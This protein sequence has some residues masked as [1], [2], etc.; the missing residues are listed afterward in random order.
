[1]SWTRPPL[2]IT[3]RLSNKN[4]DKAPQFILPLA[5]LDSVVGMEGIKRLHDE[6]R[7]CAVLKV[8]GPDWVHPFHALMKPWN[9]DF[10][11][12][13]TVPLRA[14][15]VAD[16]TTSGQTI[17]ALSAGGRVLGIS[18]DP[19]KLLPA[20]MRTGADMTIELPAPTGR[21]VAAVIKRMTGKL[22]RNLPDDMPISL[23][24]DEICACLRPRESATKAVERLRKAMG[25]RSLSDPMTADVP[26]VCDLH[27]YGAAQQW[28]LDLID[29][30]EAWRRGELDFE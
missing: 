28:A 15:Q 7:L 3:G 23:S 4:Q 21:V 16:D 20:S 26:H 29:D 24:F 11:H 2:I 8:P 12:Y 10:A 13:R 14:S 9:W 22:P 5:L 30:L 18:Q 19:A 17:S 27:G 6:P 25:D 1:M